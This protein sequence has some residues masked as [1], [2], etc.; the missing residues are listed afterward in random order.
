[1]VFFWLEFPTNEYSLFCYDIPNACKLCKPMETVSKILRTRLAQKH[2]QISLAYEVTSASIRTFLNTAQD[3]PNT[4]R[5][6]WNFPSS[7]ILEYLQSDSLSHVLRNHFNHAADLSACDPWDWKQG[8][9]ERGS[10]ELLFSVHITPLSF[11]AFCLSL[12]P[13]RKR[14]CTS[15]QTKESIAQINEKIQCL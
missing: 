9:R 6:L 1:M 7:S 3:S 2:F 15:V 10:L 13:N 11:F 5:H 14:W 12:T 8:R 4:H